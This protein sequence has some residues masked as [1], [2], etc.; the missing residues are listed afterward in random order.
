MCCVELARSVA[1]RRVGRRCDR[2][3]R[4][5][6]AA[7]GLLQSAEQLDIGAVREALDKLEVSAQLAECSVA[8]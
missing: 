3:A 4:E 8:F 5:E 2:R 1:Q 7:Q 6:P